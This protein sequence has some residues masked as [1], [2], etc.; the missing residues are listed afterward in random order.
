[1]KQLTTG[2]A[3]QTETQCSRFQLR[4]GHVRPVRRLLRYALPYALHR[5]TEHRRG[6]GKCQRS[7][8]TTHID[9]MVSAALVRRH[10]S[11]LRSLVHHGEKNLPWRRFRVRRSPPQSSWRAAGRRTGRGEQRENAGMWGATPRG[12]EPQE[13][14]PPLRQKTRS[15]G[16]VQ[17]SPSTP[18]HIS[19]GCHPQGDLVLKRVQKQFPASTR[20]V[21]NKTKRG[22]VSFC[23]ALRASMIDQFPGTNDN[24][25]SE[26]TRR[27]HPGP[28]NPTA[29][30]PR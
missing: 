20:R 5:D 23:E 18:A 28:Q 11:T 19:P 30:L 9:V 24:A 3:G 21:K 6:N 10:G 22:S 8:S 12:R 15:K 2:K 17:S 1:M 16:A 4:C 26:R 13:R 29:R 27:Y 25:K 14:Q 7:R